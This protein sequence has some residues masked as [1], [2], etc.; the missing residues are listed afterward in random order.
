MTGALLTFL[1]THVII[2]IF[3]LAKKNVTQKQSALGIPFPD[4]PTT[5]SPLPAKPQG[6]GRALLYLNGCYLL[7]LP[8]NRYRMEVKRT[9]EAVSTQNCGGGDKLD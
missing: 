1:G 3:A 4:V 8:I 6:M 2:S 5:R 7:V 9:E